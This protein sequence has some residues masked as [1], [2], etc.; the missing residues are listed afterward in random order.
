MLKRERRSSRCSKLM[1]THREMPDGWHEHAARR[2]AA[3]DKA[4]QSSREA[5]K[6]ALAERLRA[7]DLAR[8]ATSV[9]PPRHPEGQ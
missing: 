3:V 9:P 6:R 1:P 5:A 2:R 7:Q 8:E 4:E